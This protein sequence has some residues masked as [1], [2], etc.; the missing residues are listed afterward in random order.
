MLKSPDGT[1]R[2]AVVRTRDLVKDLPLGSGIVHI[3]R[4]ISLDVY[5]GERVGI[6]GPSGSG[7]ST[8]LGLM[9]GLDNATRGTVEIDGIDITRLSEGK[10]T[11]VRNEKI[12]FVFQFFNLVPTLTALENVALPIEFARKPK[13]NPR[14]RAAELLE[15]LGMKDRM[16]H[17]PAQLSGGE[18]QRVAIA[19]ALANN[20]PLLLADEPTGN[21]DTESGKVV[22]KALDDVQRETGATV[23]IVTHDPNIASAMERVLTL[24]DGQL[25]DGHPVK[26]VEAMAL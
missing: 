13:Y 2:P 22:L 3:L 18:Q 16:K 20:P 26:N 6:V 14:K 24:V 11:E 19:R 5:Q 21:L 10:L 17:R 8:L 25:I 4:G 9:G 1:E 23:V 7:K 15:L 12:G